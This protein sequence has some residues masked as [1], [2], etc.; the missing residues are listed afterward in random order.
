MEKIF[1]VDLELPSRL[2]L[3]NIGSRVYVRFDHGWEPLAAQ[4]SR[5]LRQLFLARLNV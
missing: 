3:L 2:S 5:E 4:W 1:Q